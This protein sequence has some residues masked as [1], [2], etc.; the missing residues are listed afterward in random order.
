MP[1]LFTYTSLTMACK[2][3]GIPY[4]SASK[5]KRVFVIGDDVKQIFKTELVKIKGTGNKKI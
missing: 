1:M 2:E 3:N 5:G 4:S